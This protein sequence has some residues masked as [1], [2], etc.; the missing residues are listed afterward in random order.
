MRLA[1]WLGEV[2]ASAR[3]LPMVEDVIPHELPS[4]RCRAI[5]HV[6]LVVILDHLSS[7]FVVSVRLTVC[8]M[9]AARDADSRI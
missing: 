6:H 3:L 1:T 5:V 9:R 8:D 7:S 4:R 2:L